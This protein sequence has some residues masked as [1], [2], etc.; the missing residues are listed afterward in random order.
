MDMGCLLLSYNSTNQG[1][2]SGAGVGYL[3]GAIYIPQQLQ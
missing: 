3:F 1:I 2:Q